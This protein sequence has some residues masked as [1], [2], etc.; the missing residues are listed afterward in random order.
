MTKIRR[1]TDSAVLVTTGDMA[2]IFDPGFD[3]FE[4]GEFDLDFIGD[5]TRIPITHEF[6]LRLRPRMVVPVH[7]HSLTRSARK[8]VR[9]MARSALA[10]VGIEVADVDWGEAVSV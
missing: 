9:D 3:T 1:L 10:S 7:D 5:V 6:A 8:W 4:S 2:A